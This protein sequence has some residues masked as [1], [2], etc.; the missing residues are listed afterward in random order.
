MSNVLPRVVYGAASQDGVDEPDVVVKDDVVLTVEEIVVDELAFDVDEDVLLVVDVLDN[1]F[2]V[3][4]DDFEDTPELVLVLLVVLNVLEVLDL[5]EL[6][7]SF[8]L[9]VEDEMLGAGSLHD[10]AHPN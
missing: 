9:V 6:V 4:L 1:D 7:V 8:D 3:V 5:V 2:V 10:L